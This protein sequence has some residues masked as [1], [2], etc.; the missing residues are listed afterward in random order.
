VCG[1]PRPIARVRK[2]AAALPSKK[3]QKQQATRERSARNKGR[4][5][6]TEA[7]LKAKRQRASE[8]GSRS[9][10]AVDAE[11]RAKQAKKAALTPNQRQKA[12]A[13]ARRIEPSSA[14]LDAANSGAGGVFAM[15]PAA[16]LAIQT[17]SISISNPVPRA[18]SSPINRAPPASPFSPSAAGQTSASP[19]SSI[20]SPARGAPS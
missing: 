5:E 4:R 10:K 7:R 1:S 18:P 15:A 12:R 17:E 20:A 6:A 8:L 16:V 3:S 19:R 14:D 2:E 11:T 13:A 9:R